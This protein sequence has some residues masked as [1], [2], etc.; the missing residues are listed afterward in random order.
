MLSRRT[1][2]LKNWGSQDGEPVFGTLWTM[3]L[4]MLEL[5]VI[6]AKEK[7]QQ[8]GINVNISPSLV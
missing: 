8:L 2:L 3:V 6:D 5:M 7:N 4:G 1:A